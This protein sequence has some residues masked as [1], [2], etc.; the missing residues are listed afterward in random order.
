VRRVR[1]G[2]L[3]CGTV[4]GGLVRLVADERDRVRSRFGVDLEIGRILVRDADKARPG[5]DG[6][7]LTTNALD[8][9]DSD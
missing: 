2:L 7:L 4:G 1:I 8:V 6:R 5:I 9:I 3:G